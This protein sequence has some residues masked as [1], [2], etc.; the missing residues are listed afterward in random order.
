MSR[1]AAIYFEPEGYS[2]SR[3]NIMGRNAAGYGFLR[4]LFRYSQASEHTA[5][6]AT[7]DHA[8]VFDSMA[9]ENGSTKPRCME[10]L[11]RHAYDPLRSRDERPDSRGHRTR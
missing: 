10:H 7:K 11:R 3:P 4:A 8:V 9:R 2:I 1:T 6:C 5:I